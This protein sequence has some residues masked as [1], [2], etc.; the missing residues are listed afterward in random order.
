M[1]VFLDF[2][3]T[4]DNHIP[5]P[6]T[7]IYTKPVGDG[8]YLIIIDHLPHNFTDEFDDLWTL[9]EARNIMAKMATG[10]KTYNQMCKV[11]AQNRKE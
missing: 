11:V 1:D 10:N 5:N 7:D 6:V 4:I 3:E 8:T 2:T 9:Q